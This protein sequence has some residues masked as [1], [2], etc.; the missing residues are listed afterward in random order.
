VLLQ[1]PSID[2]GRADKLEPALRDL[3]AGTRHRQRGRDSIRNCVEVKVGAEGT[4]ELGEAHERAE[5][6]CPEAWRQ[7]H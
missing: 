3:H 5:M 4:G 1:P 6:T 7:A 2:L